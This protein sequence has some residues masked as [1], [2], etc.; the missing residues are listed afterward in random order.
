MTPQELSSFPVNAPDK[1]VSYGDDSSEYGDLRL[2]AGSGP[3][4][5]AILIH[6]G[7]FKAAY[8]TNRD[9]AAMADALKGDGIATWNIEYRRVGQPGGGWP[10]TYIDV[11][12]AVDY[13]Q[14]LAR[15]Y[16][17]DLR[18]VVVV[19]HSA[20]GH[21][22]MW[23]A[24][25]GH[26]AQ[27]NALYV[28]NPL[29]VRGVV[30]LAGP[31]DMSANISGYE[32]LCRDSVITTLLGG[33]PTTVPQRY[34]DVS[35]IKLV[36]FGIPQVVILGE[37]EDF[38][39]RPIADAYV[40]AATRAGDAVRLIVIPEVGHFEIASPRASPWPQVKSAITSLLDGRL[41]P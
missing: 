16:P 38:V 34:K 17:L 29:P 26:F 5:V 24:A 18:R 19:G 20:G 33:T 30:D 2:P 10:G 39:P 41:P 31:L 21:L 37:H 13:L 6:G 40:Q 25:R 8:A 4:P 36:P 7:C 14:V 35:P 3:H 11:G 22:A 12:R 27:T 1:R 15:E 9:L 28:A 23:T 32:G